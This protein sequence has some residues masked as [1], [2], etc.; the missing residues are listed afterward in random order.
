MI[1][2][3]YSI[4]V[5][6]VAGLVLASVCGCRPSVGATAVGTITIDGRPAPAG[7][8]VDFEPQVKGASSSTGYTDANG[9][10]NSATTTVIVEA[11]VSIDESSMN[12]IRVFPN[13][14]NSVI[15][16]VTSRT[17][18]AAVIAAATA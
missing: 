10:A 7:I 2:I 1:C 3:K 18:L 15:N 8:R 13:P 12:S 9:C 14:T 16:V 5:S 6:M 11:C 4:G 17:D